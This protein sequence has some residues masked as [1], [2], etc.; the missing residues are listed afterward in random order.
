METDYVQILS[1]ALTPILGILAAYIA[2]Q[3]WRTNHLKVRHDLYERRLVIYL[4][5]ME[6]LACIIRNGKASDSE[7]VTFLQTTR[8][9]YFLFGRDIADYLEG[10][11]KESVELQ[12]QSE[13]LHS[14]GSNLPVGE[15][16][17]KLAREKGDLSKWFGRQFVTSRD[18][19]SKY[20]CLS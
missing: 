7:M 1:A 18:K 14:P 2:W 19:F 20:M 9:S 17:S 8:E 12:Y 15:D 6:F 11:Y 13:M 5:V 4:A 16:R 10:I 3:Q